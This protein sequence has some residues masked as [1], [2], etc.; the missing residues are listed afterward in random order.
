MSKKAG[1]TITERTKEGFSAILHAD[2]SKAA[3]L[4]WL[5]QA[6]AQLGPRSYLGPWLASIRSDIER[7]LQSDVALPTFQDL[8]EARREAETIR[9]ASRDERTRTLD[10]ARAEATELMAKAEKDAR[11]TRLLAVQSLERLAE[12]LRRRAL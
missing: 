10:V 8:Y 1:V 7:A 4:D 11:A 3:E 5:S 9:T 12:D 6:I 2:W